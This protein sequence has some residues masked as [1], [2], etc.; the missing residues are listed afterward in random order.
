[1]KHL[2]YIMILALIILSCSVDPQETYYNYAK[3]DLRSEI[4]ITEIHWA[5]SVDTNNNEN[6][7][8][9][10]IEIKNFYYQ[11]IDI[12]SWSIV[13]EGKNFYQRITI[14]SNTII[15]KDQIITIGRTTNYAFYYF[16]IVYPNLYIPTMNLKITIRDA[17]GK[18]IDTVDLL[19]FDSLPSGVK[20]PKLRKSITRKIG[21]FGIERGDNPDNLKSYQIP[22]AGT[23]VRENYRTTTLCSPGQ[24]IPGEF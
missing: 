16:D 11:D 22:L 15:K 24:I 21:F 7:L 17:S 14:P 23:N 9:N 2:N 8:D 20:L 5:G 18:N 4:A 12:S 19:S 13:I 6:N 10:F 3:L 1:M